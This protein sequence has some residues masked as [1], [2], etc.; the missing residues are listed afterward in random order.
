MSAITSLDPAPGSAITSATGGRSRIRILFLIDFV[1]STGGAER[2]AVGLASHLPADRFDVWVCSTRESDPR[3]ERQLAQAGV[4]HVNLGR[5]TKWDFY[6]LAG[7]ATLLRRQRFDILHTHKFGSNVWGSLIGSACRVPVIVAHEHSWAYEGEPLRAW[8][9]GRVIA[10]LATRVIAVSR[11]DARRMVS[12]EGIPERKIVTISNGYVPANGSP[13]G[14]G[15]R[16]ELGLTPRTPL[17]AVAAL[18]RPEKRLDL[19]LDA[20]ARVLR[21]IPDAHLAIAGD[22]ECRPQLERQATELGLNGRVHFLGRRSDVDN[23]LQTADVAA[24]TSDREGSPLLMFE[25]MASATPLVATDVGGIPDVVEHGATGLVV[26]RRDPD[27]LAAALISL[28]ANPSL[29]A[30]IGAAARRKLDGYTIDATAAKFA[31]LY[32]TLVDRP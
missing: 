8:L 12:V 11:A 30:E 21:T 18:L 25:C 3:A 24:L 15:L 22:G 29:C 26:P 17:I 13:A 7:V 31:E 1:S 19:L 27:S 23:I 9:D 32:E 28:L 16:S 10:R 6:R 14:D 5:R 2:F 20:H 4:H